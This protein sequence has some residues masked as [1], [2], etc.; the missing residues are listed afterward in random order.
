MWMAGCE[1]DI[2]GCPLLWSISEY[3]RIQK[4]HSLLPIL[5]ISQSPSRIICNYLFE[6]FDGTSPF[7]KWMAGSG[8]DISGCPL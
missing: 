2:S 4:A 5:K 6:L 1:L 8:L 7:V 3:L